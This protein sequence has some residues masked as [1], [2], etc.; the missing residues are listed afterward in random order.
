VRLPSGD[1]RTSTR[2]RDFD[3]SLEVELT[4]AG[5]GLTGGLTDYAVKY[6]NMRPARKASAG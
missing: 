5:C 3:R 1:C 2:L 6:A 4:S